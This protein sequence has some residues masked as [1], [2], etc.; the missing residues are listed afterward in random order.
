MKNC[1]KLFSSIFILIIFTFSDI[2]CIGGGLP[3]AG[4]GGGAL[5]GG[6]DKKESSTVNVISQ[7]AVESNGNETQSFLDR[8][9][10]REVI[11]RIKNTIETLNDRLGDINQKVFGR[12]NE[13]KASGIFNYLRIIII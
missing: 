5:G 10:R 13:I 9:E 8:L 3:G 2:K 11:T 12:L 7:N 6:D 4:G 1:N